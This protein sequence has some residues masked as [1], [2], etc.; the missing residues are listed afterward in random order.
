MD[1]ILFCA[2][3][4]RPYPPQLPWDTLGLPRPPLAC[5]GLGL[6]APR[7]WV[8]QTFFEPNGAFMIDRLPLAISSLPWASLIP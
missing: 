3:L 4:N 1:A 6:P 5:L 8:S 2:S 7:F